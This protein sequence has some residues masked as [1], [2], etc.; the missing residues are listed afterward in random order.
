M[1]D[2]RIEAE[3]TY[4][5]EGYAI[6]DKRGLRW[7]VDHFGY[8]WLE[9]PTEGGYTLYEEGPSPI[10]DTT[11]VNVEDGALFFRYR[12]SDEDEGPWFLLD[13]ALREDF[14]PAT[15]RTVG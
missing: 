10:E 14:N 12:E 13:P 2:P 11:A 1:K 6:C 4:Y 8:L 5:F 9:E 7:A 3:T 15:H